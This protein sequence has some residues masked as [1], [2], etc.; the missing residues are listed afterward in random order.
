MSV[1]ENKMYLHGDFELI[2]IE[3]RS[4]PERKIVSKHLRRRL[5][6]QLRRPNVVVRLAGA[7]VAQTRPVSALENPVWQQHFRIPLA[8]LVSQVE[9][10][11]RDNTTLIAQVIGVATVPATR[12]ASG[13]Q[14][15]EWFPVIISH[16]MPPVPEA[17]I[18]LRISFTPCN[19]NPTYLR[20]ISEDYEL[21]E[22]YFPLRHGGKVTLY[23]DAHVFDGTIPDIVLDEG[24]VFENGKCWEDICH[25]ILEAQSLVYIIGW[26]IY[27]KVRLVRE[28]TKPL[29][30]GGDLT[31]G[32]LLK[33]KSDEGVRVL[34]LVWDDPTSNDFFLRTVSVSGFL[35]STAEMDHLYEEC[36]GLMKTH[37][38]ETRKFFK[39]SSVMCLLAP[40]SEHYMCNGRYDTPEHRLF[41]DLDTVFKDDYYNA[42][43]TY[44]ACFT[45]SEQLDWEKRSNGRGPAAYDVL[46]NFEQRWKK[47]NEASR[48]LF[49][50]LRHS[51]DDSVIDTEH[52]P[53][54]TCPSASVPNDHP[55]LWV[56][57]EDDP[58]QWHV[59]VFRTIDSGSLKGFPR[60]A[61]VAEEQNLVWAKE[62][63]VDRSIQMAYIQAIRSAQHFVYI[64][65]QYF[66]GSSFAW[67]F[68]VDS[69]ADN[70]IPMEL[71]L[72]IASKIRAKE[73][74]TVYIVIPMWP[75]GHPGS[76]P[77]PD[78][79]CWQRQTMEMMY[80]VVAQQIKSAQLETAH[81]TDYL[82]FYCLGNRE[83]YQEE[84]YS[85]T[86]SSGI[87]EPASQIF[88]RFMIYVHSKGII[89]DDA[90]MIIGSANI[91]ERSMAGSRDTEIAM[92]A[93]R[94]H[95]TWAKKKGHPCGHSILEASTCF[96]DPENLECVKYVNGVAE[97]N[98]KRYTAEQFT[99]LQGHIMKY[100][101]E[102]DSDGNVKPLPG[103]EV[104]PDVLG[105][106]QGFPSL[107]PRAVTT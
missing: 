96:K 86:S 75:E 94:P 60:N 35:D 83:Q 11:V 31:L 21:R 58:E 49:K 5:R 12:I 51:Y 23:Q 61:Y 15:E 4:L 98:W 105:E 59:Q 1:E 93:Y 30:N 62:M 82:N 20:G 8:H 6:G 103:H 9:F 45:F 66:V 53:W 78:I 69:G 18:R 42:T 55:S 106:I 107:L 89:V 32:E 77:V 72:K 7:G 57:K 74:F 34:L 22:S 3:A 95:Y 48:Y 68:D 73:R 26:S 19:E 44:C 17:A 92:G 46:K 27:H 67:P 70:L 28:P 39:H 87:A 10:L 64:E 80:N 99:S 43:F 41:R 81:P 52:D 13:E 65:N 100:P 84:G 63:A 90:Y 25:A 91:N 76:P 38:E 47:V 2:I 102:V 37:D 101:A 16:G 40:R 50:R 36:K 54:I 24:R 79:L 33:R 14:I 71:A 29:P 88:Q 56:S 85:Q 97:D 104:F